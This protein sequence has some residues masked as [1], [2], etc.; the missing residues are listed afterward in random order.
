[1]LVLENF[2][3]YHIYAGNFAPNKKQI[4]TAVYDKKENEE[5]HS[6]QEGKFQF[7]L[8]P[9]NWRTLFGS[10]S[11]CVYIRPR[12]LQNVQQ[13]RVKHFLRL[14]SLRFV[15]SFIYIEKLN[16]T[17]IDK[18]ILSLYNNIQSRPMWRTNGDNLKVTPYLQF[19]NEI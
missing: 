13:N 10:Y 6:L 2:L 16:L 11:T 17:D 5:W 4:N 19:P 1:M 15:W 18:N 14:F 9:T 7:Q 12:L 8:T 3:F